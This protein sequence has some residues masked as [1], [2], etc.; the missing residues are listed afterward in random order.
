MLDS[1]CL[2][3]CLSDLSW[4]NCAA[5]SNKSHYQSKV[6]VGHRCVCNQWAYVDSRADAVNQLLII[7]VVRNLCLRAYKGQPIRDFR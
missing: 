6:F 1:I 5:K 4:L 7:R 3:V 2:S